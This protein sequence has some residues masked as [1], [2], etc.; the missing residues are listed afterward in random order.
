MIE[1][2]IGTKIALESG[3]ELE[4]LQVLGDG[5]QGTVYKAAYSSRE[6]ALKW[7]KLEYLKDLESKGILDK[8]K[9]NIRE[10]IKNGP[11]SDKFIWPLMLAADHED[12]FGYLMALKPDNYQDFTDIFNMRDKFGNKV[13][14]RDLRAAVNSTLNIVEAFKILHRSGY[15]YL[16]LNDGNFFINT[17]NGDVLVCDNDNAT[18]SPIINI[19]KPGYMAPELVRG[20]KGVNSS[21]LTDYHSLAVVLF[22]L[23]IRHDPLMGKNYVKSVCISAEKERELYGTNPV[24]IFDPNDDS[25]R[26][27]LN[28][29]ANP[30]NLWPLYPVFIQSA[31]V[32]SFSEGMKRPGKRLTEYEWTKV[33]VKLR[34]DVITCVCGTGMFL[35]GLDSHE[36]IECPRCGHTYE[37]PSHLEFEDFRVNIFPGNEILNCHI[38]GGE[39]YKTVEG[40]VVRSRNNHTRL[41][42]KNLSERSWRVSHPNGEV[43]EITPDKIAVSQPGLAIEFAVG[44]T[45]QVI[46]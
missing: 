38:Y 17:Q 24:F 40:K 15:T 31:F 3:G 35:S 13:E 45:A 30:I 41:G 4:I 33:L 29:H 19:G 22:K 11:P 44:A 8:F 5:G 42:I 20:D 43:E 18:A 12:S 14:F 34:D 25:N 9:E 27:V 1:F 26:P 16:D 28:I 21:A 6:Y 7:Y 32:Q 39:D 2:D 23:L 37:Y 46:D 10:N 36:L